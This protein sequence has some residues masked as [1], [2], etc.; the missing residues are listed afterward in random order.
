[1]IVRER[2]FDDL[3]ACVVVLREVHAADEYP[4]VW[5]ADTA[6][7]LHLDEPAWVAVAE[8]DVVG[9]VSVVRTVPASVA[10]IPPGE[11]AGVSRLFVSPR[12]RGRGL[13]TG[14]ALL[15]AAGRWAATVSRRLVLDVVDDGGPAAALYERLG[16][17][18]VGR[19]DADWV[20]PSGV[21]HRERIYLAP[22]GFPDG[23]RAAARRQD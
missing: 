22:L 13:G 21:R 16:W 9:H 17:Q 20:T 23:R 4:T 11:C 15:E 12:V 5:P 8:G 6:G 10:G 3:D 7:W 14:A 2:T 18:L 1:M 19:R